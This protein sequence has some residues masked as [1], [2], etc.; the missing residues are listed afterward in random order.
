MT[1]LSDTQAILLSSAS[2]RADGSLLPLPAAVTPGGGAAKAIAALI[3]RGLAEE[4][5]TRAADAAHRTEGDIRFGLFI[6]T[7]GMSVIGVERAG[8]QDTAGISVDTHAADRPA[9][10]SAKIGSKKALVL[11]LLARPQ[12]ATMADL[13]EATGWLPHTTRAALTGIRKKGHVVTRSKVDGVT[14]YRIAEAG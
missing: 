8:D 3:K 2:Q 5:E 1:K 14:C 11:A 10:P 12:G 6:S 13:V 9:E 7:A 4:R